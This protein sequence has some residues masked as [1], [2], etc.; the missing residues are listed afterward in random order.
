[1]SG[2]TLPSLPDL[3]LRID[4]VGTELRALVEQNIRLRDQSHNLVR[5]ILKSRV[6]EDARRAA[7]PSHAP[8]VQKQK[9][10]KNGLRGPGHGR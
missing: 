8:L 9:L 2:H 4:S 6:R 10:R 7:L 1:M 3:L 5:R